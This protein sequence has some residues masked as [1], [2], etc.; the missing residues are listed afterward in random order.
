M[1]ARFFWIPC[2]NLPSLECTECGED[3]RDTDGGYTVEL[4]A[5]DGR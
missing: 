1:T 4:T 2:E 5:M 3:L